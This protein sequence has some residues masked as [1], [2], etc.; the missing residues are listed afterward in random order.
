MRIES[1]DFKP[2]MQGNDVD[3]DMTL[4]KSVLD[5][6][7]ASCGSGCGGGGG[8]SCGG[9]GNG[10]PGGSCQGSCQGCK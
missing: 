5:V 10:G 6:E 1:Q 8:N 7:E 4:D 9:G 2:P 3:F